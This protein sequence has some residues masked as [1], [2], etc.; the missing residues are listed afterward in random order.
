MLEIPRSWDVCQ[1]ELHKECET[2]PR[3]KDVLQLEEV[4]VRRDN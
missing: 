1:G 4:G 2:S 3:E